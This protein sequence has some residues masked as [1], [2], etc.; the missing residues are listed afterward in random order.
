[1]DIKE[2][3]I[4][5]KGIHLY[6]YHGVMEQERRI[7]AWYTVD[8]VLTVD[9]YAGLE[10]D[11]I[12]GTVSYADVYSLIC[13]EMEKPSMLLE[14]VCLRISKAL[15]ASFG[16]ISALSITLCKDT[17]PMGGDRLSAAVTLKSSRGKL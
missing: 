14:N 2:Y 13:R 9:D 8:A 1:M 3:N 16:Q 7:G 17:P 12:E 6:A 15:Y 10:S 5:L 4:E 11:S